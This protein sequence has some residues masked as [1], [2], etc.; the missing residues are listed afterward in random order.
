MRLAKIQIA[1]ISPFIEI[2]FIFFSKAK[3]EADTFGVANM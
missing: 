3:I 2:A 1:C